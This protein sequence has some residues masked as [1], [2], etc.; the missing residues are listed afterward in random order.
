MK[1]TIHVFYIHTC[2]AIFQLLLKGRKS[3]GNKC[4]PQANASLVLTPGAGTPVK[5][6]SLGFYTGKY[7]N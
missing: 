6:K 3:C 2:L 4:L 5:E 7:G 1:S